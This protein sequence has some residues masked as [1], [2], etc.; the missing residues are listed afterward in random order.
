[1]TRLQQNALQDSQPNYTIIGG[2]LYRRGLGGVLMKCIHSAIGRQ[3]IGGVLMVCM[4]HQG[5]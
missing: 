1:M 5:F 2:L 3:L 4:L